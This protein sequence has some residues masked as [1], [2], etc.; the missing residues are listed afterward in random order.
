MLDW[1]VWK[2]YILNTLAD[3]D[4]RSKRLHLSRASLRNKLVCAFWFMHSSQGN[5]FWNVYVESL[6]VIDETINLAIYKIDKAEL[7]SKL[8]KA[9]EILIDCLRSTNTKPLTVNDLQYTLNLF[10]LQPPSL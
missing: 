10:E 8:N 9:T 2:D 7:D 3:D 4:F 1:G 6:D 5:D